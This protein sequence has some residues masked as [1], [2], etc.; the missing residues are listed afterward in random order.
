[1]LVSVSNAAL[2]N[3]IST[4]DKPQKTPKKEADYNQPTS[5]ETTVI[6]QYI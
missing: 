1:M 5:S 4:N 6:I 2:I 3:P